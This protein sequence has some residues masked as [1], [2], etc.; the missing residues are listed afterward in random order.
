MLRA[1]RAI[2]Y[3]FAGYASAVGRN[4]IAAVVPCHRAVAT[5]DSLTGYAGGADLVARATN[6]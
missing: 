4:L 1:E 5:S 2:S 6:A 3:C